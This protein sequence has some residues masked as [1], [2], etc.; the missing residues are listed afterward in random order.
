MNPKMEKIVERTATSSMA[1]TMT[2]R[3]MAIVRPISDLQDGNRMTIG[4]HG[5]GAGPSP[6]RLAP[7]PGPLPDF[8]NR[9]TVCYTGKRLPKFRL[10]GDAGKLT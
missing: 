3:I 5:S 1:P 9:E 8:C 6:S 7:D 10:P 2:S 4:N